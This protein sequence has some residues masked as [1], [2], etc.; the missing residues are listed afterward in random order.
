LFWKYAYYVSG[1]SYVYNKFILLIIALIPL[2]QM[3]IYTFLHKENLLEIESIF[4]A[5][6]MAII[7]ITEFRYSFHFGKPN[8][9]KLNI[10]TN[11]QVKNEL[12]IWQ[13][14]QHD[15][16]YPMAPKCLFTL[17]CRSQKNWAKVSKK[18]DGINYTSR[19]Y[20][21]MSAMFLMMAI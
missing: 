20:C 3:L 8:L 15:V 1:W 9:A 4:K 14:K 17:K 6:L 18:R 10:G 7:C 12:Q 11:C 19:F 21:L 16:T 5:R 13:L 2:K